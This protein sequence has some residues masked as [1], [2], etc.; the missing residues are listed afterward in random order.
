MKA[1]ILEKPGEFQMVE[2]APPN[3]PNPGE[4]TVRVRRVGICGT[5][6][7]AFQ[8]NQPFFQYPR[9]LGHELG[10]EIVT[11]GKNEFRLA[12]G[13]RCALTPYVHCGRCIACRRGKTNCCVNLKVLGVHTDGGMREQFNVSL[14][15]LHKSETLSLEHLA[16]IETLGIGAHAVRRASLI[17]E[18]TVLIVGLGPI[19]LSVLEFARMS[20]AKIVV[21]DIS[22][23]RIQF[24]R[25]TYKIAHSVHGKENPVGQLHEVLSGDLPTVVFDCTGNGHSMRNSFDYVAHGGKLVFVGIFSGDVTFHDPDFH[26]KEVTLFASRNATEE[27]H[28]R[29][30]A[31]MEAGEINIAPWITHHVQVNAVINAFPQWVDGKGGVIKAIVEW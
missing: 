5:D 15:K 24:C 26:R 31:L 3:K 25:E 28:K 29:I 6:F 16:L 14:T 9:I 10:V 18:D 17:P 23:N 27:E 2:V 19:G 30:L 7:H 1:I 8:G 11:V 20:G 22:E 21:M 13:D 12:V 4:A